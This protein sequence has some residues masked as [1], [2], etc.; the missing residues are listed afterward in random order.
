[1]ATNVVVVV[2]AVVLVLLGLQDFAVSGPATWNSLHVEL[3]TSS[4]SN[5]QTFANKTKSNHL[6]GC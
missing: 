3:P 4:L 1:M 6:F 2:V 5:S